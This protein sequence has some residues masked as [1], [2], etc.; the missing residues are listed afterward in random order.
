[1]VEYDPFSEAVI[2]DPHPIYAR[3]REEAPCYHLEKYDA[4]A[5]SRFEDIWQASMDAESY[6][7]TKGTTSSHLLTRVQPVTPMINLMDPPQHTQLRSKIAR[8]FTPGVVRKL[9]GRIQGFVDQAFAGI[10]E[11]DQADLFNEFATQVSVKV[12]CLANGFPLEDSDMLNQL[13]WRFFAREEGVDGI[14]QDGLAAM[15]EMTAYF[16]ELI[17]KRRAAGDTEGTVIDVALNAEIDG[18]RFSDEE[19]GSHLSMFLI[20]G[21]ETFPKVFSSAIYRLWQHPAQR[22]RC[23]ADPS[24]IPGA[25]EEVLRYDM[26]TQ[27]LM[28]VLL[29]DV[30]LHGRTMRAG[31]SVMFLYPSANRDPREFERADAFDIDRRPPRILTFGHGIHTCIGQHFAKM[32]GRLCLEKVL[33]VMPEYEVQEDQL[34]RI[35]TEFVQGWETMPVRFNR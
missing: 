21:A 29:K 20:G 7:A 10:A 2:R 5:L 1:M 28:R 14:T 8:F 30:S 26:P 31:D 4:W 35:R 22:A 33:P 19:A 27:F 6:T 12:A 17:Q 25:F 32:E 16:A 15:G 13:V 9:E 11:R 3:L 18:R 34:Q 23:V 24:L